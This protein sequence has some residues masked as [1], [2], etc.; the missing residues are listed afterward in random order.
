MCSVSSV[1]SV[2]SLEMNTEIEGVC[3]VGWGLIV[4]Y[5]GPQ[6]S[7]LC[8]CVDIPMGMKCSVVFM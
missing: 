5:E 4:G 8:V 6:M 3:E 1:R 2:K 7:F